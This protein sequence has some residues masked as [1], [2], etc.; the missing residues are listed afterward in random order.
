M[1]ASQEEKLKAIPLQCTN[2]RRRALCLK[3]NQDDYFLGIALPPT[4]R[5]GTSPY[6]PQPAT[7]K[8]PGWF[9]S[10]RGLICSLGGLFTTPEQNPFGGSNLCGRIVI[11]TEYLYAV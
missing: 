3:F 7:P 10:T 8:A 9:V 5:W 11:D 2:L 4:N 6:L 1:A